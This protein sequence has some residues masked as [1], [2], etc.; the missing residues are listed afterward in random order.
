MKAETKHVLLEVVIS[1]AGSALTVGLG[2]LTRIVFDP[3]TIAKAKANPGQLIDLLAVQF[4]I[5]TIAAT[6]LVGAALLSPDARGM[7]FNP[8]FVVGFGGAALLVLAGVASIVDKF[9]PYLLKFGI[10][11]LVSLGLLFY[12]VRVVVN[13]RSKLKS[14]QTTPTAG[15]GSIGTPV[16]P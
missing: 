9:H 8:V 13:A 14:L 5:I 7:L 15:A 6:M 4:D 12:S 16:Q 2:F 10:P 11:D 1:L 3:E